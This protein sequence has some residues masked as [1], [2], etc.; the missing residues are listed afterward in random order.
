L[1]YKVDFE[2]MNSVGGMLGSAGFI[3]LDQRTT[4]VEW[5]RYLMNFN[6]DES[7]GK[8]T[9]CRLGCPALTEVL[10]RIRYGTGEESD[11]DLI[12]Y[13]GKQIIEISLCGLGQAA[14]API[15]SLLQNYRAD[16]MSYI[17]DKRNPA[18]GEYLP[19]ATELHA[20]TPG[21][22]RV[23]DDP[24]RI[25]REVQ[26]APLITPGREIGSEQKNRKGDIADADPRRAA[27]PEDEALMQRP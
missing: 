23:I 2:D 19:G 21:T 12:N 9:P 7:C 26:R 1:H 16:F 20:L 25:G 17:D 3:V 18:T 10:D 15:L 5:A 27:K 14:P 13:T 24:Y 6:A 11:L 8:C 22:H 4:A